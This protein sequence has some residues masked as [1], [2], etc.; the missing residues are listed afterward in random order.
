MADGELVWNGHV[1]VEIRERRLGTFW[2]L[3][4]ELAWRDYF[5]NPRT[6]SFGE[7]D[8]DRFPKGTTCFVAPTE[9]LLAAFSAFRTR[10]ADVALAN[11][12]TPILRT[13]A[14]Q[15]RIGIS[16]R[17]A[18]SYSPR[19]NLGRFL[20]TRDSSWDGLR[21]RS[22]HAEVALLPGSRGLFPA[23]RSADASRRSATGGRTRSPRS[24]WP[25]GGCVRAAR[26][27]VTTRR[28]QSSQ[29]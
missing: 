13:V 11:D 26:G 1:H 23:E 12:D 22:R 10:Y 21:R 4:A 14:A 8:F 25:R 29:P 5:D 20:A 7:E 15:T 24:E 9:V 19:T 16:P 27:Q 18:C 6:T 2:G 17:F 28:S 3:L